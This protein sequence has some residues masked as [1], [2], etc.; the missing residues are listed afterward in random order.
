MKIAQ[1][2][3]D[4]GHRTGQGN[5]GCGPAP[6]T[7]PKS[8]GPA[9]PTGACRADDLARNLGRA[10]AGENYGCREI[11]YWTRVTADGAGLVDS[12]QN[13]RVTICPTR[14]MIAIEDEAVLPNG[15]VL[16]VFEMGN[17]NQ[18][19]GDGIPVNQL[20]P[21]SFQIIPFVTDCLKAGLPFR[22]RIQGLNATQVVY[23]G[24]IGPAIG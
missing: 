24:L 3:R 14:V 7:I 21:D 13:S 8:W 12:T 16:T 10:I 19:V 11:P 23:F 20:L 5:G 1:K 2:M 15:T 18:I 4:A 22:F 9:C 6:P 17:Q